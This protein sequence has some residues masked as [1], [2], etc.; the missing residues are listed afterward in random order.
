MGSTALSDDEL[1]GRSRKDPDAFATFYRR[2]ASAVLFYLAYRTGNSEEAVDLTAEVFAAAFLSRERFK[3]GGPPAR[4]WLLGIARNKLADS[5]RRR[6][7]EDSARR[8]LGVQPI[9]ME[10]ADLEAVEELVDFSEDRMLRFVVEDLPPGERDAVLARIV[11]EREYEDIARA[12][13][14]SP[15]AA[16]KRVSRGLAKLEVW[17]KRGA[18]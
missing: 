7:M 14:C 5:R 13:D 16:R 12:M 8:R 17:A 6:R 3:P 10:D 2:H 9:A 4:A 1:L 11:E 15:D 18:R